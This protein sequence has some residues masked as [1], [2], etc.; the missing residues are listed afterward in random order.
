[1]ATYG[2]SVPIAAGSLMIKNT[3]T[4][5]WVIPNPAKIRSQRKATKKEN[6]ADAKSHFP[7]KVQ[8]KKLKCTVI[9]VQQWLHA[10]RYYSWKQKGL[11]ADYYYDTW[12][13]L[14]FADGNAFTHFMLSF[15][16]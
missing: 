10:N 2:R 11:A 14:Y 5:D 15:S 1:M 9:E 8:L 6:L 4:G 12:N 16:R 3:S 7:K 13:T